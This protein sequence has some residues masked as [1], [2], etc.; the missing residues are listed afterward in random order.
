MLSPPDA[1]LVRR[2]TAIPGLATLLDPEAYIA[3][4][5]PFLP[6]IPSVAAHPT[7]IRYKPG[8][9]CLVACRLEGAGTT[10][11]VYAKAHGADARSKLQ[12]AR[13]QPSI[14]GPLSPGRIVFEDRGIVVSVFPNDSKLINLNHLANGHSRRH[15]LVKLLS[16]RP[17]LSDGTVHTLRYKPERR[18][19]TQLKT[20]EGPGAVLKFYT[21]SGYHAANPHMKGFESRGPLRLAA[22]LGC[23]DSHNILAYEWLAGRLLR[24][25]ISDSNLEVETLASVGAALA[26]LHAQAPEGLACRSRDAEVTTLLSLARGLGWLCPHLARQADDLA[27][28][29]AAQLSQQPAVDF[30]IHGDFYDKQVLVIENSV[31]II[32]LDEA[33]R[34]DPMAD[35]GLFIAHLHRD[36]L[37]GNP[38]PN[39]VEPLSEALLE[40]Y[41]YA[42]QQP[43]PDRIRLYIAIGLFQL[44][45]DPFRACEPEWTARIE[46]ILDRVEALA[47]R[48]T[49]A[50]SMTLITNSNRRTDSDPLLS[51]QDSFD[52]IQDPKMSLLAQA[53]DPRKAALY[54]ER[55][56]LSNTKRNGQVR[57]RGIRALRHK[58]GRRCLVEYDVVI[59]SPK[60]R[61]ERMTLLGK[62]RASGLDR[63]TYRLCQTLWSCGFHAKSLDGISI[64]QPIG[65][66]PEFQM[67]FQRKVS[68]IPATHLLVEDGGIALANRIAE[69]IHKVHRAY[70]PPYQRHHSM[71]DE[72]NILHERL[73]QVACMKQRWAEPVKHILDACDR[74]GVTVPETETTGIH[75][76]FY[77][78]H[79]LVDGDRLYL[80]DFDLYCEGDPGLD[81]GNFLGHLAEQSL[82]IQGNANALRDRE[83]ALEKR[84]LNLSGEQFR[85]SIRVYR[86]LTLVRHIY[87]STLFP[88]RRPFTE[89]LLHLCEKHLNNRGVVSKE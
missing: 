86:T 76:D 30:P 32:D 9:N 16:G 26:E 18:Y 44:A 49:S 58:P 68:G 59:E 46:A 55:M 15:L 14:M 57:L 53:F 7:Y 36:V 40:G 22:R 48:H 54:L 71:A 83:K 84:F 11:E 67:W 33:A 31:A 21:Q 13:K 39:R 4:L 64:P 41:Q 17:D 89:S 34:G 28:R 66:I 50:K 42:V 65:M 62:M 81:I 3:T 60:G 10:L 77:P 19:V 82:R 23:S 35:L 80:L 25:A 2:D 56:L 45:H 27:R 29:L 79:V 24:D 43:I 37:C 73:S 5:Q 20:A 85:T 47:A 8:T 61:C 51:V 69:A 78:E 12:K 1:D 75:R 52:A 38:L 74:L 6:E 87:I 63:A 72:L 88:E 70:T